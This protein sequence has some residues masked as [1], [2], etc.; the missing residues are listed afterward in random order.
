VVE[1]G[2]PARFLSLVEKVSDFEP[3]SDISNVILIYLLSY[4]DIKLKIF[5]DSYGLAFQILLWELI[6]EYLHESGVL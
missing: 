3:V 2:H 5:G 6:L 1:E 4:L